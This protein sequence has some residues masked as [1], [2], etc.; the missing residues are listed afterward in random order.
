MLEPVSNCQFLKED[1][2]PSVIFIIKQV[3]GG[4][5]E[6]RVEVTERRGKRRNQLLDNFKE[7]RGY[8]KWKEKLLRK[9]L[10]TWGKRHCAMNN[11][12]I[13]QYYSLLCRTANIQFCI[14]EPVCHGT[15]YTAEI[16]VSTNFLRGNFSSLVIGSFTRD[17]NVHIP[18]QRGRQLLDSWGFLVL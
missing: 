5:I 14:T 17:Y 18:L 12:Y 15:L 3:I 6:E 13:N 10:W 4:K 1:F 7:T 8:W 9:R 11:A 2:I 16:L